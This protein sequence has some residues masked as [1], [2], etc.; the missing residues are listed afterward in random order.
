MKRIATILFSC[1]SF[2]AQSQV[3][4]G[5]TGPIQNNGQDTYFNVSVSGLSPAQIDSTFGIETV[6]ININHPAI[7]EL[8]IY[9]QSP[10][11]N[12]VELAGW[13]NCKG[14]NYT[15]TCFNSQVST[16][17][18]LGT[19]PYAGSYRPIGYL[20]RFNTGQ[21]GN[22]T[23]NLIVHDGVAFV[24]AGSVISWSI[25]FGN[26]PSHP[27]RFTSS[28]LPIVV[29][30]TNNQTI[31]DLKI[32]IGMGIIDNGLNR[33]NKTDPFNSY[34]AK[35]TISFHGSST[36]NFEK[37]PYNFQTDD[38]SGVSFNTP[39]LGMPIDNDWV[40]LAPYQDK[41]LMRIPLT[42]DL[43]RKMGHYAARFKN[44][45]MILN[46][47]YQGVY[48]V[49]EKLKQ[50]SNRINISKLTTTDN[51]SPNITGGY[52]LDIDRPTAAGWSSLFPGESTNNHFYYQYVYPKDSV[53]T[54]PQKAYIKSFVDS[55]ET[56]MNS[57]SFA[58]PWIG[59]AKYIA[60]GSFI[61]FFIVNELS[62][63]TD[64]YKLSTYMYKDNIAKGGKLH[65][66]PVWD[67]DIAWHNCDYGNAFDPNLWQYQIQDTTH[68]IPTWWKR[69]MKDT[70]FV[71][72]LYCRWNQLR[73]NILSLNSLNSYIDSSALALNESQQ[74]NFIQ[75]PVLGVYIYPNPQNQTGATYQSEV[76][77]VKNWIANRVAWMDGAMVDNCTAVGIIPHCVGL[78]VEEN[79]IV[80]NVIVYPNPFQSAT[81]FELQLTKDADV[82][83][84]IVDVMGKEVS[85][86]VNEHKPSGELKIIFDRK[87]IPAG[88]Y[89]YQL[90][91]DGATKA[92]KIIIQ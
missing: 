45:E 69:F 73:Q 87:Q 75:W 19:A 81:I 3:F 84:K 68:P 29:L 62:K 2:Y 77:D 50:G 16:S 5:T 78:G 85:A 10:A 92:G 79:N 14:I 49:A 51:S 46:N 30:N 38:L 64:A 66:G 7:E 6:C 40:L 82:S 23:W 1:F 65:I 89:F 36:K 8:Y 53:I 86:L 72:A 63:N 34:N 12:I 41:S 15:N 4:T 83:L 13:G 88:I 26:S 42:Y 39:L 74:R 31:S 67:Y 28:N 56:V 60:V 76:A 9:L 90:K 58:D 33:N 22:G 37:K 43:Y 25:Q 18:T 48:S 35:A 17:V 20:G 52:I 54:A 61:D 21:A 24:N 80:T 47:E 71:N 11:G 91:I 32:I 44:V 59:Y 57:P 70:T 27:V 55:F